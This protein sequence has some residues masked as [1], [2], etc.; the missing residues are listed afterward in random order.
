MMTLRQ[1]L[2]EVDDRKP[3]SRLRVSHIQF[4]SGELRDTQGGAHDDNTLNKSPVHLGLA[5][6]S[7][8]ASGI[9]MVVPDCWLT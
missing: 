3:G 9:S 1:R 8:H 7:V 6:G 5:A 2:D 4:V